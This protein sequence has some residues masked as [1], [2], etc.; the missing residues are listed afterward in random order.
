MTTIANKLKVGTAACAMAA[1]AS[2]T[3]VAPA[4]AA[5]AAPAP[6]A[7][8]VLSSTDAPL[9]PWWIKPRP[10]GARDL[11]RGFTPA[12][13]TPKATNHHLRFFAAIHNF[14]RFACYGLHS[15]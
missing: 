8:V 2:L 7:P 12:T 1:A 5:P 15:R 9:G 11:L 13:S 3:G 4:Q 10:S 6:A 14:F